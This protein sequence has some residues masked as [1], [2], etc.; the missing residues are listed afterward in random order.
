MNPSVSQ[1][2]KQNLLAW[3][4]CSFLT[5]PMAVLF[6]KFWKGVF[7]LVL[8]VLFCAGISYLFLDGNAQRLLHYPLTVKV[9]GAIYWTLCIVVTI[10]EVRTG[11]Q[12]EFQEKE[13]PGAAEISPV[14]LWLRDNPGK[15]INDYYRCN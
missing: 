14:A 5:G 11:Q 4:L 13:S 15:T 2:K 1:H 6:L 7:L 12:M 8:P 3:T 9:W 10:D